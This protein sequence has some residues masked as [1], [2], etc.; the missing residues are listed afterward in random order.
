VSEQLSAPIRPPHE[1]PYAW[2]RNIG[3]VRIGLMLV[4][5]IGALNLGG[6]ALNPGGRTAEFP[7]Y[8]LVFYA[9]GM[10]CSAGYLVAVIWR[11]VVTQGLAWVFLLADFCFVA[12]TV[13]FTAGNKSLFTF[14]F[15]L[16]ILEAGLILGIRQSFV[17]A[18][19]ATFTMFMLA[20]TPWEPSAERLSLELWYNFV[21]QALAFYLTASVAGFWNLRVRRLQDFQREILDDMNNGFIIVN[22]RGIIVAQNKAADRILELPRGVTIG[23][24]IIEALRV[25]PGAECPVVTAIRSGRDFASYEFTC[26]VGN[27]TGPRRKLLGLTTSR[28]FGDNDVL[29]MVIASFSDLTEMARMRSEL[30]RQDRMAVVGELAAGLAHEI[31]NPVAAIRGA[32]DELEENLAAP[33]MAGRLCSIAVREADHLNSIVSGFLDFASNPTMRR[34]AVDLVEVLNEV[35][36]SRQGQSQSQGEIRFAHPNGPYPV[37]GDRMRLRQVFVNII[38]NAFEAMEQ[39]GNLEIKLT[40]SP[41]YAEIR[42]DDEGPGIEPDK[43]DR[44]FEPFYTTRANGV[45]MGLAVCHRIVTAHDGTI[46]ATSRQSGGASIVVRLPMSRA[47]E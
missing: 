15:V 47:E 44:I 31:R 29:E 25:E 6:G 36:E 26:V 24:N 20:L 46:N 3:L 41:T 18:T 42:F 17:I 32:V 11:P 5:G 19:F 45:G 2:L 27:P 34:D 21:V 14:V 39:R 43:V 38:K 28:V 23:R 4:V 7:T 40:C 13:S 16:V 9:F 37:R 12:A 10:A 1:Y 8:L 22:A 33:A 35:I 30:Q